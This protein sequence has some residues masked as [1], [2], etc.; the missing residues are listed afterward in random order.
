[1]KKILS[2]LAVVAILFALAVPAFAAATPSVYYEDDD[3]WAET[4]A[5][6]S[7]NYLKVREPVFADDAAKE[8]FEKDLLEAI[9]ALVPS[10]EDVVAANVVEA[11]IV[12]D[13]GNDVSDEYFVNHEKVTIAFLVDT[14]SNELT[15]VLWLKDGEWK[16]VDYTVG[17]DGK[18]NIEFEGSLGTVAFL[19]KKSEP[20]PRPTPK[21]DDKGGKK[22]PQT[23]DN[24]VACIA[25][26]IVLIALGGVCL[27]VSR[28][29]TQ[30]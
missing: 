21:P 1:M 2:V 18:I 25:L 29:K 30:A 26:G 17:E 20:A 10:P 9:D 19:M 12:D 16:S 24:T 22:S 8:E 13:A 4:T 5:D 6:L 7:G 15:S 23:G 27:T 14:D 11:V 3:V 28:R